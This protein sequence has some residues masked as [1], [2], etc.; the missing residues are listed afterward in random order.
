M[1]RPKNYIIPNNFK[2]SSNF[3]FGKTHQQEEK[4]VLEHFVNEE[5]LKLQKD[6]TNIN[7]EIHCIVESEEDFFKLR[8]DPLID[9]NTFSFKKI[10][11]DTFHVKYQLKDTTYEDT[12]QLPNKSN[13]IISEK[14]KEIGEENVL[15]RDTDCFIFKDDMKN[16]EEKIRKMTNKFL[17]YPLSNYLEEK[18][19]NM[20]IDWSA[21]GLPFK[22]NGK[23]ENTK[24]FKRPINMGKMFEYGNFSYYFC[25]DGKFKFGNK[26]VNFVGNVF[27]NKIDFGILT[28]KLIGHMT[29]KVKTEEI[30]NIIK[31]DIIDDY[32]DIS[33]TLLLNLN[34]K[35]IEL[36][37]DLI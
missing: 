34:N 13:D 3:M 2:M 1:I 30:L 26:D 6:I 5:L 10:D 33:D 18:N 12:I 29:R 32:L 4:S 17:L 31:D 23:Y 20:P 7:E 11:F 21:C 22:N 16:I 25:Y 8:S 27:K 28:N 37:E 19:N 36:F 15:Y 35:M 9:L 14:V 24:R